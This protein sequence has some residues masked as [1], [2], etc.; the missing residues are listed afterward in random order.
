MNKNEILKR[1]NLNSKNTLMETLNIEY[2][3]FG[4]DYLTAKMPVNASVH[5]PLGLLHGGATAALAESV[6]SAASHFFIDLNKQMVNGIELTINH[7]KSKTHGEIYATAKNIHKGRTIHLWEVKIVDQD[8]RLISVAKMTNIILEK[9]WDETS[10]IHFLIIQRI[11]SEHF[12]E[13]EGKSNIGGNVADEIFVATPYVL[14]QLLVGFSYWVL[15]LF[16]FWNMI[17]RV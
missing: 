11:D 12:Y 6:G 2:T 15:S 5:Q 3:D 17:A 1:F 13:T 14:N 8:N 7:I 10:A 4:K 16:L 9:K